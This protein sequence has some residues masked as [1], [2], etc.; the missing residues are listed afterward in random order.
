MALPV[1]ITGISTAAACAGPF[2]TNFEAG[3][4]PSAPLGGANTFN[5]GTTTSG[6]L[7]GVAFTT[8]SNN[9]ITDVT[10]SCYIGG[11][12]PTDG[13]QVDIYATSGGLPTGASLGTSTAIAGSSLTTVVTT[14]PLVKFVFPTPVAVSSGVT[15]AAVMSR[16]GA[17]SA[18]TWYQ[19][20]TFGTPAGTQLV[21]INSG[22]GWSTSA[23]N[24][25]RF[26][27]GTTQSR[28][29]FFGRDS[30]QNL[31]IDAM[32]ATDPTSSWTKIASTVIQNFTGD[33]IQH[34][35]AFQVGNI[36]HIVGD[37]TGSVAGS[38]SI[39]YTQYNMST[40]TFLSSFEQILAETATTGGTG[41]AQTF[42]SVV[43]RSTGDAIVFFN[44]AQTK[45]SGTYY[46]RVYYSRRTAVNTWSAPV[47]VDSGGALDSK[48]CEAGLILGDQVNL[49][50]VSGASGFSSILSVSNTLATGPSV[51]ASSNTA[52]S[53]Q[54][55]EYINSTGANWIFGVSGSAT[56]G[57]INTL[58]GLATGTSGSGG[59]L[60]S[61]ATQPARPFVD[62]G[63]SPP[64]LYTLY[65]DSVS[66]GNLLVR[67]A[68]DSAGPWSAA[69]TA[70]TSAVA[71][72]EPNLSV[73]GLVYQSGYNVVI[74]YIVNDNGTLKYNEYVLRS[75]GV[76][77]PTF[78]D[79]PMIGKPPVGANPMMSMK[80]FLVPPSN[81]PVV[82]VVLP[83]ATGST[84]TTMGVG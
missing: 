56:V 34:L 4:S 14:V 45:S 11:G 71:A 78:V 44:G 73:D 63:V 80:R 15:Y 72:A 6:Q 58:A 46:A 74:P 70:M 2:A 67:S 24:Y 66:A 28:Y 12:S 30:V 55:A 76:P 49:L 59:T 48:L 38:V 37:N 79:I 50:F 77:P 29:Y 5:I 60:D 10:F 39:G 64:I 47:E 61:N 21:L 40:D 20:A 82:T 17:L 18:T 83:P 13:I 62:T 42:A 75:L 41:S 8:I 25:P 7:A 9:S 27:V 32:K 43:V 35:S 54:C 36:V 84:L 23:G 1:T 69:T 16:T 31:G 33:Q 65:R 53:N 68:S 51:G 19:T 52:T 3:Q 26:F 22:S 57:S 81:P